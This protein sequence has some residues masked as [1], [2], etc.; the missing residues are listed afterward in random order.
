ME[1][2]GA[3]PNQKPKKVEFSYY[4][5][6]YGAPDDHFGVFQPQY[7]PYLRGTLI[8]LEVV[9]SGLLEVSKLPLLPVKISSRLGKLNSYISK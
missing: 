8:D 6:N 2:Y 4:R 3:N 9:K 1:N 5:E 7:N